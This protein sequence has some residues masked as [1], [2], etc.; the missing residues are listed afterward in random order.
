MVFKKIY[1][2][3]FLIILGLNSFTQEY[4]RYV[5]IDFGVNPWITKRDVPS[6]VG[7]GFSLEAGYFPK[8]KYGLITGINRLTDAEAYEYLYN[9]PTYFAFTK[10]DKEKYPRGVKFFA[11]LFGVLFPKEV[12]VYTGPSWGY[13][14]PIANPTNNPF[15]PEGYYITNSRTIIKYDIGFK[16]KY[17][18]GHFRLG[19]DIGFGFFITKNFS[20]SSPISNNNGYKPNKDAR[21]K[22]LL[23]YAF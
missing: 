2:S 23:D 18:I 10:V 17:Y 7:N 12:I 16:S 3:V 21:V 6:V 8:G 15:E 20:L 4:R 11:L 14:K 22:I 9:I 5:G 13:V 19:F 1:L